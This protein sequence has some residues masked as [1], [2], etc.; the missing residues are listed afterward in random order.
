M[1]RRQS[2]LTGCVLFA[3]VLLSS[4]ADRVSAA[5]RGPGSS[6]IVRKTLRD[7]ASRLKQY[8]QQA[9]KT[10]ERIAE[11]QQQLVQAQAALTSAKLQLTSAGEQKHEAARAAK[12]AAEEEL[13]LKKAIKEQSAAKRDYDAAAAPV[14]E[15]LK[16]SVE[17]QQ[18]VEK[19][20]T[21]RERIRQPGDGLDESEV[22][23]NREEAAAAEMAVSELEQRTLAKDSSVA[24]LK[25]RYEQTRE[26]VAEI[27]AEVHRRLKRDS[28][29][30]S[31]E[32]DIV[33]ARGK[34]KMAEAQM[35]ALAAKVETSEA[36]LSAG[37]V[38]PKQPPQQKQKP[39]K[40]SP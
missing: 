3:A 23:R 29:I 26:H 20:R 4:D 34:V 5:F 19:A 12:A 35:E 15:Q 37:V 38:D 22:R 28:T 2:I 39:K 24:P 30:E 1:C 31:A 16:K 17:H 18:A 33:A 21:T 13:G 11:E 6:G 27:H 40:K 7:N 8:A 14:L 10:R 9:Q 36:L 25:H 32:S